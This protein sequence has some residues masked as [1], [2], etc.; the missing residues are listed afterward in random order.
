MALSPQDITARMI[1]LRNLRKLH[2]AQK[3]RIQ[4][5]EAQAR[6]LK[7]ENKELRA[8]NALL[9]VTVSD[10]QLQMEELRTM[11]FGKKRDERRHDDDTPPPPQVPRTNDS[12]HR[13][14]PT[15]AEV[16]HEKH[17]PLDTCTHCG[18]MFTGRDTSI[19]FEEDIPLPQKKVITSNPSH[20][21]Q[22]KR[23]TSSIFCRLVLT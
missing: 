5:L 23:L 4:K 18:L 2:G 14:I 3:I 8:Q 15:P 13:K 20:P 10:I 19:Y 12:Y 9:T 21:T 6:L 16:T 11:V 7:Q 17:H 1:E 22:T